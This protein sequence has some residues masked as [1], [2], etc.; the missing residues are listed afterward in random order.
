MKLKKEIHLKK[1]SNRKLYAPKGALSDRGE[2]CTLKDVE[3]AVQE[4][5][6][7]TITDKAKND[8]SVE[9]FKQ[10]IV[11][12]DVNKIDLERVIRNETKSR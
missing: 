7:V 3:K 6:D 10:V 2:Y 8:V 9:V 5:H 1:Y 4:G 11:E 12:M